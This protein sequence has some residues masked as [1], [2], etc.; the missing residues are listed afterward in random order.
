MSKQFTWR[1]GP[2]YQEKGRAIIWVAI[3]SL[4]CACASSENPESDEITETTVN[5]TDEA[6]VGTNELHTE[7]P[8]V[9]VPEGFDVLAETEGDLDGDGISEKVVI[10]NTNREGDLG[11]ERE[12]HIYVDDDGIWSL[13]HTSVG[14]VMASESG[15]TLGDPFEGISIHHG[16]L[17]INHFGGSSDRWS[18]THEFAYSEE[19]EW[20]LMNA[21]LVYFRNCDFSETYTYDLV[22]R[23]GYHTRKK[24]ACNENGEVME[25]DMEIEESLTLD[26]AQKAPLMDGFIPGD[27]AIS[28]NNGQN[29]YYY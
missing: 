2:T 22:K 18:Y 14:P 13:W 4:L 8:A 23:T 1:F 17:V 20:R 6:E 15:G 10:Y 9:E 16:T 28:V 25:T 27:M 24:D 7:M 3:V 12:M 21:S 19:H 5:A 29:I 11:I 26:K